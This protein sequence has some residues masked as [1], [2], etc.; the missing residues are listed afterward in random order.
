MIATNVINGLFNAHVES[1]QETPLL[2]EA[3]L[4]PILLLDALL[5]RE[6]GTYPASG[7]SSAEGSC[8]GTYPASGSF[9]TEGSCTATDPVEKHSD[10]L[11]F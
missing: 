3:A 2:R 5:L 8:T 7:S 4:T 6:A 1:F 10:S 11:H 9:S